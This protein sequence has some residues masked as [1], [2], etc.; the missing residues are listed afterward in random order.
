QHIDDEAAGDISGLSV[1]LSGDGNTV[2]IG[3]PGNDGNGER[4][5]HARVYRFDGANWTQLG[6]DIDGEAADDLS[7]W[8]VSLSR[9]GNSVVIGAQFND[10][11]GDGAGQASV[12][13]FDGINW[14]Q[15]GRDIDGEAAGDFSGWSVSLSGDGNMVA[16]G[17]P[18]NSGGN[19]ISSGH[20]RVYRLQA[21]AT[22]A[23]IDN[24]SLLVEFSQATGM[25]VESSGGNLPKLLV[26]GTIQEGH[27]VT[28]DAA[29]LDGT[30][31]G[32]GADYAD[33]ATVTVVGGTYNE[34]PV[35]ITDLSI[36]D[37]TFIES[38]ETIDL[39]MLTGSQIQVG[40]V[41][42]DDIIQASTQYTILDDEVPSTA[43][44]SDNASQL[45]IRD[46]AP[47]GKADQLEL[48][49]LNGM[50][51]IRDRDPNNLVGLYTDNTTGSAVNV[52]LASISSLEIDLLDGNDELS[53]NFAG[54]PP[55]FN[56][57]V[58]I[59]GGSGHDTLR[60]TGATVL[61]SGTLH[62]NDEVEDI[63][64]DGSITMQDGMI[65]LH[66]VQ[67]LEIN[68]DVTLADGTIDLTAGWDIFGNCSLI[69]GDDA[70]VDLVSGTGISNVR[71]QTNR[72][73]SLNGGRG[74]IA[75]CLQVVGTPTQIEVEANQLSLDTAASV[76]SALLQG[77]ALTSIKPLLTQV[78]IFKGAVG[79]LG[80][81]IENVGAFDDQ[82]L[83]A[84]DFPDHKFVRQVDAAPEGESSP[85]RNAANQFD[86]N[87]D[88]AVSPVDALAVMNHLNSPGVGVQSE[89]ANGNRVR[90]YLDV[91]GDRHASAIDALMIINYLNS[92]TA[93][94][95]EG[96]S[97]AR[98]HDPVA[99][100]HADMLLRGGISLAHSVNTL[101]AASQPS[102]LAPKLIA[103][104]ALD[105]S[106]EAAT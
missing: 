59:N 105:V 29:V 98:R 43:V 49:I 71:I 15:L 34:T 20:A 96:E 67:S 6:Q 87:D 16:I 90:F 32:D 58:T 77:G 14:T 9:D 13:R 62:T 103:G 30:A 41:N 84:T 31:T 106:A 81:F 33:P 25:D 85:L 101:S 68:A 65:S 82:Q 78:N 35:A 48:T 7:G 52:S 12:Y 40:D 75:G 60:F 70:N 8:S 57:A 24:D 44:R 11:N 89:G 61:D 91:N 45:T 1:S 2:V 55:G 104:V 102:P 53:I 3:A 99:E 39:G 36:K 66:A 64:V 50:L 100:Y 94:L 17:A 80:I 4:A 69:Q 51:V 10:G 23:I 73:V 22:G 47:G 79:G 38:D 19:G 72:D 28:I 97:S 37:D 86:V 21:V 74:G 83:S 18:N 92:R 5:G 42:N 54:M 56:L 88:G 46:V 93:T 26:T 27:S 63:F 95:A 76:G